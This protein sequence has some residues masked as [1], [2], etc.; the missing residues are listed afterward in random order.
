[1]TEVQP[2]AEATTT[3]E[4]PRFGTCTYAEGDVIEFPWGLPGFTE[5]RRFLALVQP[6]Q[7]TI[8][9]LQS[10]EQPKVAIPTSNPW[11][12]FPDYDPELPSFAI[13]SLEIESLA[14]FVLLGVV[15]ATPNTGDM[16]MNLV[17]PVVVNLRRKVARQVT[18]D[19]PGLSMRTPIPK[20]DNAETEADVVAEAEALPE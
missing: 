10:L 3:I 16:T 13:M 6:D 2:A 17:A 4:L 8:I 20:R 19:T 7:E 14:D 5:L 11:L 15:V 9:W 18:L 1:M 12:F